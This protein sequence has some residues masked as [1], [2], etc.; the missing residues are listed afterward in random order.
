MR[1]VTEEAGGEVV[2]GFFWALGGVEMELVV[3]SVS[4]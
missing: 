3:C 4:V 1:G 2:V